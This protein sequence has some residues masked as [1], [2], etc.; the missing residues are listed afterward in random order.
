VTGPKRRLKSDRLPR[1]RMSLQVFLTPNFESMLTAQIL[2]AGV[3]SR[4]RAAQMQ[5]L[6][7]GWN[8]DCEYDRDGLLKKLL[9]GI[10]ECDGRSTT[11]IYPDIIVHHRNGT[12]R[13][14]NL[15]TI[16]LKQNDQENF[17]D[18]TKLELMTRPDGHYRYQLGLTSISMRAIFCS[19]VKGRRADR[20][21]AFSVK[22][23]FF[24]AYPTPQNQASLHVRY[25]GS[26]GRP[27]DSVVRPIPR[28]D[29]H[30]L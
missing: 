16:E 24:T 25:H 28:S 3:V 12:G 26:S 9:D 11:I 7:P 2:R 6:F 1:L 20:L 23:S 29:R 13:E 8:I 17:C 22:F 18:R 5:P 15:L 19:P 4:S 21:T 27:P 14:N 10:R 30:T